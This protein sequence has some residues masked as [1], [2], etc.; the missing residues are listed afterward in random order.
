MT[1]SSLSSSITSQISKSGTNGTHRRQDPMAAAAKALGM[2][3][4]DLMSELQSG[5]SLDDVAKEK[6][7]SQDTLDAAVKAALPPRVQSSADVDDIVSKITSQV[8]PPQGPQG[9]PPGAASSGSGDTSS[10]VYGST[11]TADQSSTLDAL[12]SL[13][14]TDSTSLL[15]D[16]QS[17]TSLSDLLS[18][19]NVDLSTIAGIMQNGL[20]IDTSA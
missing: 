11:L 17:G 3:K 10:G 20:L 13:L 16:L 6:G 9:P 14:G 12:S 7:V 8:G 4:D 19:S 15:S 5:K 1:V 2:S 18:S